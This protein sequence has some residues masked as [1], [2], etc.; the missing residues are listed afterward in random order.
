[1]NASFDN[2]SLFLCPQQHDFSIKDKDSFINDL[3][4][5]KLIAASFNMPGIE[6]PETESSFYSG[7]KFLDYIAYMGCSPAIEFAPGKT[8]DDNS[9]FCHITI[10]HF[11]ASKLIHNPGPQRQAPHCPACKKPVK[12]WQAST[13]G[14]Q[15]RCP[16]C[17]NT[18]NIE[19]YNWRKAA[20]YAQ[21][22]IE[23]T[24]IF[25]KEAIPQQLLL[26]KLSHITDTGW[27]YFYS[28]R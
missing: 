16:S 25:P 4:A 23:I 17:D 5:V 19:D 27:R 20:G 22:F 24:D 1:M 26:D 8:A 12:N 7:E 3:Q 11:D 9:N 6:T 14:S 13:T 21:L 28:C 10:H 2:C 18:A 15:I